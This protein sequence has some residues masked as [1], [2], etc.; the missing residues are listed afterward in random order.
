MSK[1]N[2]TFPDDDKV[3]EIVKK[4]ENIEEDEPSFEKAEKLIAYKR[5]LDIGDSPKEMKYLEKVVEILQQRGILTQKKKV[6]AIKEIQ[7]K[8]GGRPSI[9]RVYEYLRIEDQI[10]NLV[11]KLKFI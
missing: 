4:H 1:D 10:K 7:Y 8:I 3:I 11:E 6:L 9:K 5:F 2:K